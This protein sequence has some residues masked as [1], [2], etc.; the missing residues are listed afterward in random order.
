MENSLKETIYKTKFAVQRS[1]LQVGKT[2]ILK[3]F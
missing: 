3:Y 1:R 2:S